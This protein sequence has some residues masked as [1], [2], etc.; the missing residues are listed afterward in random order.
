MSAELLETKN[1][2]IGIVRHVQGEVWVRRNGSN[3]PILLK[4]GDFV[5]RGDQIDQ[6]AG[7]II[8]IEN[9]DG[10]IFSPEVNEQGEVSGEWREFFKSDEQAQED[11]PLYLEQVVDLAATPIGSPSS[12]LGFT[13]NRSSAQIPFSISNTL[14]SNLISTLNSSIAF[15]T[16]AVP[17]LNTASD[18]FFNIQL[19]FPKFLTQSNVNQAVL[20]RFLTNMNTSFLL[21]DW[22]LSKLDSSTPFYMLLKN[23]LA[24]PF[25]NMG[26]Q[27]D[28]PKGLRDQL[29]CIDYAAAPLSTET[30]DQ[31]R[32]V[33]HLPSAVPVL[34]G[35]MKLIPILTNFGWLQ[36]KYIG[37]AQNW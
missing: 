1:D 30:L 17:T 27:I 8:A 6:Q 9:T 36:E 16:I 15:Q 29:F 23:Q 37:D 11:Q 25:S 12:G 18:N 14:T 35:D 28:D 4:T 33:L 20:T 22:L 26:L 32:V 34:S 24:V 31:Y 19:A 21:E 7:R 10:M 5:Y 13:S 3:Q 2:V